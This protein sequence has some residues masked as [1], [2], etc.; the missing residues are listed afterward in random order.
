MEKKDIE[1]HINNFETDSC[2]LLDQHLE[3]DEERKEQTTSE[4][5]ILTAASN[6]KKLALVHDV[7]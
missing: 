6:K 5:V 3:D 7:V 2:G 4:P 1:S